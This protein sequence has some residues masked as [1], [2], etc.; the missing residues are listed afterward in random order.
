MTLHMY[1]KAQPPRFFGGQVCHVEIYVDRICFNK[2]YLFLKHPTGNPWC[3]LLNSHS[4]H[5]AMNQ[6]TSQDVDAPTL[7]M[8]MGDDDMEEDN[9][10]RT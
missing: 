6:R 10:Q 4:R 8:Q 9:L 2:S 7:C 3:E 1:F 5:P